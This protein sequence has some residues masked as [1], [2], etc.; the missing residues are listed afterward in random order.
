MKKLKINIKAITVWKTK[1][2][3]TIIALVI[4]IIVML[5]LIEV[6]VTTAING[7]LIG[8][9]KKSKEET[10]YIQVVSEKEMWESGKKPEERFGIQSETLDEFI[11]RL[12]ENK[13]LTAEEAEQ[14][15]ATGSVTIAGNKI[16]FKEQ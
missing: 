8:T 12:R 11:D 10:R 14:A 1:N 7:D 2:G 9:T 13:L 5:I 4:T 16:I 6:T 3:I 15:K